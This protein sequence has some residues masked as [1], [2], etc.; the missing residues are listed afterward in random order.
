[1]TYYQWIEYFDKLKTMPISDE[2]INMINNSNIDY[3]GNMKVRYLNHIVKVINYRLNNSLDNFL[4]KSKT[5]NQNKDSIA[6]ELNDLKKEIVFAKKL[7]SVKHFDDN[8]KEQLLTNIKAFGN[9]MNQSIRNSY[10]NCN[11]NEILMIVQNI[12]FNA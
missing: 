2:P 7:A 1:M 11:N 12:D 3:Q 10:A 4:L 5:I 6:I 8:V 9:E